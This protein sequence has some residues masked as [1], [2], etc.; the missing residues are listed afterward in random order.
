[1]SFIDCINNGSKEGAISS[2]NEIELKKL[3]N[4]LLKKY[5]DLG[6]TEEQAAIKAARDTFDS[7]EM[8]SLNKKRHAILQD[9]A[10]SRAKKFIFDEYRDKNG[11]VDP[12]NALEHIMGFVET[13]DMG[14]RFLNVSTQQDAIKAK[15]H[16]KMQ[17]VLMNFRANVLGQTR[18]KATL[19]AMAKEIFEPGSTGNKAAQEMAD[20]WIE[21]AELARKLFNEAGGS[22]PKAKFRYLPQPHNFFKV[23]KF[24]KNAW[25]DRMMQPGVL[26]R[27]DMINYQTGKVFTDSEMKIALEEAWENI[28]KQGYRENRVLKTGKSMLANQKLDHRFL[29][30]N[31]HAEWAKYQKEF[32]DIDV[33]NIMMSHLDLMSRDIALL[34]VMGPNP[35]TFVKKIN[36]EVRIWARNTDDTKLMEKRIDK[37]ESKINKLDTEFKAVNGDLSIP[38]NRTWA[39]AFSSLR[40]LQTGS[41]LGGAFF[42]G[43]NDF[44]LTGHAAKIAGLPI[45]KAVMS[46]FKMFIDPLKGNVKNSTR[47]KLALQ[48]GFVAEHYSTLM[49]GAVRLTGEMTESFEF[50]RRFSDF[51]LRTSLL[52]WLTQAGR[53]GAG[54]EFFATAANYTN[55]SFFDLKRINPKFAKYLK[56]FGIGDKEWSIIRKTKL[57]NAGDIDAKWQGATYLRPDDIASR[58]DIDEELAQELSYKYFHAMQEFVNFAVPVANVKGTTFFIGSTKP[59]TIAGEVMRSFA[60]FKQ[61]P[62][63]FGFTHIARG[64]KQKSTMGKIGYLAPLLITTTA[65]GALSKE[66]KNVTQGRD[67]NYDAM[68]GKKEGTEKAFNAYWFDALLRGGGIGYLGDILFGGRF[69]YDGTKAAVS[70]VAGPTISNILAFGQ[71]TAGNVSDIIEGKDANFASELIKFTKQNTPGQS[72]WYARLFLEKFIFDELEKLADPRGYQRRK[73][74]KIKRTIR[75]D[76]NNFWWK[77]GDK[78]PERGPKIIP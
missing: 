3:Y 44:N 8:K 63:T 14:A 75:D 58:L 68:L 7:F 53:W 71:L 74:N 41:L 54:M 45:M 72:L 25:V 34:Q 23:H 52:S 48:L 42:L 77:P 49:S 12:I 6:D 31:N 9:K 46:N 47:I 64:L 1:M 55:K 18:N 61:F 4:D 50:S 56:S 36:N 2:K 16:T 60:Q 37:V 26:K 39:K 19:E 43:L 17:E 69:G 32:G 13:Y 5:T 73:K 11:N 33:Y 62:L 10:D 51:V 66:L 57:F 35:N 65:F 70:E 30:F 40:Q 38:D 15:L 29:H 21:A 76:K 28:T 27:E 59:G 20:A 67:V 24:G 78:S 22:I